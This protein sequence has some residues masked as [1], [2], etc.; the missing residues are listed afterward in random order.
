VATGVG[1]VAGG[2]VCDRMN[3]R[4][5]YVLFGVLGGVTAAVAALTPKTP[6]CFLIFVLSYQAALGMAYAAYAAA[7][8]EAI[9]GGAAATKYTLFASAANLPVAFLMPPL[10][11]WMNTRFGVNALLWTEL[12]VTLAAA[13]LYTVLAVASRPRRLTLALA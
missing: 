3:R 10:D 4:T 13:A 1:A 8:L 5:A 6:E 11:G 2:Y 7:N 9:G 12:D